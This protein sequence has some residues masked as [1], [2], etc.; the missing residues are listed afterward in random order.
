MAFAEL[1][2]AELKAR[3]EFTGGTGDYERTATELAV[4][5]IYELLGRPAPAVVFCRS[6]YQMATLPS[7]LIGLFFSDAWQAVSCALSERP[8]DSAW[9]ADFGEGWQAL[10]ANGGQQLLRGMK[11]SSR[12]GQLYW[13]LESALFQQCSQE[14]RR[15]LSSGKLPAFENSL[16]K[17]TIY[18]K[19][20]ALQLWHLNFVQDRL[21]LVCARLAEQLQEE[22]QFRQN[23]WQQFLPYQEQL[24][25]LYAGSAASLAS[26]IN[27]MG[28]EPSSQM[29]HCVWLPVSLPMA[30]ACQ[31]W[32]NNVDAGAFRDHAEEI[33]A[34]GRLACSTLAV[35]CLDGV[36]FALEKPS[37]FRLDEG[38][39]LHHD[40]GP[41]LVFSDGFS[42]YSWHGVPVEARII[43]DPGSITIDE[44]ESIQNAETRR[45]LIERYGQARYLQ[46]SGAQEIQKDDFGTLYKKE[47]PGDE[48]LVMVKVV[49]SSPE[50]DGSFKEYFLRV[51]PQVETAEQ[52]VAWTF[53][54]E[55]GDYL[56]SHE[57]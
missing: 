49:N 48:P 16:P 23:Q 44:I 42:E 51:P 55:A 24:E 10:W 22:R 43:E 13:S 39:R 53:G 54:F 31:I 52:A 28:A 45:V 32:I 9:Q 27:R 38:G 34:W 14:L 17:E 41:A 7:I 47:I 37:V 57:S 50:P 26:I 1:F 2:E 29:K 4:A 6:L 15:W 18:R 8:V 19:F 33:K 30:A 21:R 5:R 20:W 3:T 12:I 46:E 11:A 36:V 25:R 40:S 35:I 56:P